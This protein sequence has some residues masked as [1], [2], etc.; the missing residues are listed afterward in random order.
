MTDLA[1][2][3]VVLDIDHSVGPLPD[4]LVLPLEHWQESTRFC[5]SLATLRRFRGMLDELLPERHG[6]VFTGSGDFHHLSWPLIARLRA[7]ASV[8]GGGAGQPSGQH[9][10]PIRRALRLVGAR[11]GDVA[12]GEPCARARHLLVRHRRS[13][14]PGRTGSL[15]CGVAS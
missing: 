9:A 1:Q 3:P 11:G 5:C 7:G 4:R 14:T 13:V 8:P 10:L 12:A 15:R 2:R 6:T